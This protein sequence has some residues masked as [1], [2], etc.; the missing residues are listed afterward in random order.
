MVGISK[1][2]NKKAEAKA[3]AKE[4]TIYSL[5]IYDLKKQYAVN[6]KELVVETLRLRQRRRQNREGVK[7]KAEAKA[8]AK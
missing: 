5:T 2:V 7:I 3:K 8:K 1:R 6:S 4:F